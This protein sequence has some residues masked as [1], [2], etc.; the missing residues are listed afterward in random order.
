MIINE[1]KVSILSMTDMTFSLLD[2][3]LHYNLIQKSSK[4]LS[5]CITNLEG[6]ELDPLQNNCMKDLQLDDTIDKIQFIWKIKKTK[7]N[8]SNSISAKITL[9]TECDGKRE[10]L[11]EH[12]LKRI[13]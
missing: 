9:F 6:A 10:I 5:V 8:L 1:F 7:A 2:C 4:F 13:L 3:S 12:K 11:L